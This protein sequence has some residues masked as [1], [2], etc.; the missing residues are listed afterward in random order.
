MRFNDKY[1]SQA[2]QDQWVDEWF[3]SKRNG[4]F[5]EIGA[6]D[7]WGDSNTYYLEKELDWTGIIFECGVEDYI[8]CKT[9]RK[10][11]LTLPYAVW[12]ENT[13]LSFQIRSHSVGTVGAGMPVAARTLK[14]IFEKHNVP[15]LIDY[16]SLDIEG[17]ELNALRG[18]PWETHIA[19][20]WTIE[21]NLY[22]GEKQH[23]LDIYNFMI[24]KGYIRVREDVICKDSGMLPYEDWF[25][26]KD[27]IVEEQ[28]KKD[29]KNQV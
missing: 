12:D 19:I 29:K 2:G 23:K 27:Y 13:N 18:F 28:Q 3:S 6:A 25:V 7:G 14:T 15:L 21:H 9:L 10:K 24:E 11:S 22:R 20:L 4:Y 8:K 1:Y 16:I 26:H 5:L 17:A